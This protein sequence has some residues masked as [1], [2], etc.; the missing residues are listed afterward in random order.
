MPGASRPW[1]GEEEEPGPAALTPAPSPGVCAGGA[2]PGGAE[3]AVALP[4]THFGVVFFC[5]L[6]LFF[7]DLYSVS[8]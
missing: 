1:R 8:R 4:R 5:S 7:V 3:V 2:G 6:A